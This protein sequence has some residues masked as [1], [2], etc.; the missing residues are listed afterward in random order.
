MH[1][2]VDAKARRLLGSGAVTVLRC[3]VTNP[4]RTVDARVEGDHG[5]YR[6]AQEAGWW[7]CSCRAMGRCSHCIAVRLVT[8]AAVPR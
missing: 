6:V 8:P 7:A 2:S 4:S 3:D 1:E 5:T